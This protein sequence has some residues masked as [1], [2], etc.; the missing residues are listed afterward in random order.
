MIH[1]KILAGLQKELQNKY[2]ISSTIRHKGERGRKRE[3][4]VADFLRENLPDAC[5][6]GTGELFSFDVEGTSPQCDV[7]I[8][9]RLTT[10]VF[11]KEGAVQQIPIEGVFAIIEV[12]SLL[13]SNALKDAAIKFQAIRNLWDSAHPKDGRKNNRD[14]G[15]SFFLFGFK[16]MTTESSCLRFLRSSSRE[17]CTLV[18]LDSGSSIWVGSND[19][20]KPARPVWLNTTDPEAGIYSTLAFFFFGVLDCCQ[21][22]PK[23][24]NIIKILQS[25]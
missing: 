17:D 16:Q 13:D 5:G 1:A 25:C 19:R 22:E 4:G 3:S 2:E 24:F 6:V 20:T 10:P 7:I 12:R 9:D 21:T 11:G 15:P 8:Y 18:A 23:R 14:E